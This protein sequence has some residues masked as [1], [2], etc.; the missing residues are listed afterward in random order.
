MAAYF[1]HVHPIDA[2]YNEVLGCL[3]RVDPQIL[4]R[5]VALGVVRIRHIH[6]EHGA[7]GE[8]GPCFFAA[9]AGL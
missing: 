3:A 9:A 5:V 2:L 1:A 7:V 6:S 4:S 8:Q